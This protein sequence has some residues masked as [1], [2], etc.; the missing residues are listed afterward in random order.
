MLYIQYINLFFTLS[1]DLCTIQAKATMIQLYILWLRTHTKK[2]VLYFYG[3][4]LH[5]L[6]TN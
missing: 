6:C 4:K 1:N 3:A 5:L 2:P